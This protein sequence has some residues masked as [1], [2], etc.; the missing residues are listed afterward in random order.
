MQATLVGQFA[1][2]ANNLA[3]FN[4]PITSADGQLYI[5]Y[6]N[7]QA[8]TVVASRTSS[9]GTAWTETVVEPATSIDPYHTQ[10]SI[11]VDAYGY[12]WCTYNMHSSPW[13]VSVSE[14]PHDIRAFVWKGQDG[15]T[16][17]GGSVPG[18]CGCTG[19]CYEDW[20]GPGI[21]AIPGNQI[22]YQTFASDLAGTL[23]IAY[24]EALYP[25]RSDYHT[26]QWSGG[27]SRYNA[28]TGTWSRVCL[29]TDPVYVPLGLSAYVDHTNRLHVG[30]VWGQHYTAA[31][32][33]E[34]FNDHPNYPFYLYSDDGGVLWRRA[35][36]RALTTPIH[37]AQCDQLVPPTW[38]TPH[39][40][41]YFQGIT[42]MTADLDRRP[43]LVV[44]PWTTSP[45]V[46]R[47]TVSWDGT[48][49]GYPPALTPYAAPRVFTHPEGW[50]LAV[51]SGIR[52]HQSHDGAQTWTTLGELDLAG[53]PWTCWADAGYL[54]DTGIL[55][56]LAYK[57]AAPYPLK[58]WEVTF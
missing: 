46:H 10:P 13:R 22:T 41:G 8:Q 23:Y 5:M 34:A 15:G 29:L 42:H 36:G 45:T 14:K 19:E 31:Q 40:Q 39:T 1:S 17:P 57:Q 18:D 32:G 6:V 28:G 43:Y 58:V 54:R 16:K 9:A 7:A 50:L 25:E 3:T 53:G 52:L 2:H 35:D 24:R 21:A 33:S 55:R 37:F 4:T 48:R 30:G 11:G 51:S 44:Q 12:I 20:L 38:I 49:W 27:V 26:R 47:S 56:L